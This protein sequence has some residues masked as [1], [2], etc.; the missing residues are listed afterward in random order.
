MKKSNPVWKL[1]QKNISISQITGFAVANLV[2]LT[3]VMTALQF[4]RDVHHA[5]SSEEG[6]ISRDFIIISKKINP[7]GGIDAVISEQEID[8]LESQPWV[9]EVGAFTP[10]QFN[11]NAAVSFNGAQMS[12]AL[13]FESIPDKFID[14]IPPG[15]EFK[16]GDTTIPVIMSKDYLSLYNFGF[17]SARGLPTISEAMIG[18]IPLKI[19]ISGNGKQQYFNGRI[20]GFSSRLNTI[21][22][23]ESFMTWANSEFGETASPKPSRLIVETT[24]PGN[25][26]IKKYLDEHELE[27]GRETDSSQ[28]NFFL[29]VLTSIV[30]GIGIVICILALFILVLS[31]HLLLQKNSDKIRNLLLLGYTTGGVAIYYRR[32][33]ETV[34]IA[35]FALSTFITLHIS[36]LWIKPLE[37]MNVEPTTSWP[38]IGVGFAITLTVTLINIVNINNVVKRCF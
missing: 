20:A 21:A 17:A 22:V 5:L 19:S 25:P 36:E 32:L 6:L 4:Y 34:N 30:G 7:F 38:T 35:V 14:V 27:T 1:L 37:S 13:F 28:I 3:I 11:V 33:V 15:W 8:S 16:K 2:G 10:S 26:A 31:L 18:M 29:S 24:S 9:K 12:T 23:P